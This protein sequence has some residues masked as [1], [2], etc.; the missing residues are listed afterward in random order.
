MTLQ[1]KITAAMDAITDV[2]SD[3][4][5][6]PPETLDALHSVRD[7]LEGFV[8]ATQRLCDVIKKASSV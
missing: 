1:D 8:A 7:Y 3:V 6:T 2:F 4:S 5:V